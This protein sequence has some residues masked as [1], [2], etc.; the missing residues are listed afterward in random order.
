[1]KIVLTDSLKIC[2]CDYKIIRKL[3]MQLKTHKH[4]LNLW[5]STHRRNISNQYSVQSDNISDPFRQ[6]LFILKRILKNILGLVFVIF[7]FPV[8]L[9]SSLDAYLDRL[10]DDRVS[11]SI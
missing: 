3:F 9:L 8:I 5:L 6:T 11:R 1:M 4:V 10:S 2:F 7:F